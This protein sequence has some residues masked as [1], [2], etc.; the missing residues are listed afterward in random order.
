MPRKKTLEISTTTYFLLKALSCSDFWML[1]RL[2]LG[3]LKSLINTVIFML[4]VL[5]KV[6]GI[7][8]TYQ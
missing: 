3:F 5:R 7:W 4:Q 6:F 2:M 1:S 8:K